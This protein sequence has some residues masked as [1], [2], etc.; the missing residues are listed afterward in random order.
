MVIIRSGVRCLLGWVASF[1]VTAALCFFS[2][3]FVDV[4]VAR[5]CSSLR[6]YY[7]D[8]I[9][10]G[11]MPLV[12]AMAPI[13]LFYVAKRWRGHMPSL[14]EE[15][16]ALAAISSF[17]ALVI[18]D[19]V[20]KPLFGRLPVDAYLLH[21][22]RSGFVLL[23]GDRH[24][25]FPSG[26]AAIIS[27]VLIVLSRFFP[28]YRRLYAAAMVGVSVLLVGGYWHFVSDIVA[29]IFVGAS[30]AFASVALWK[31]QITRSE[32]DLDQSSVDRGKHVQ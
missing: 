5:M 6:R 32:R 10:I 27:S 16:A 19:L 7:R 14:S 26:H 25:N 22:W 28:R 17:V 20:L 8:D 21:D 24:S 15:A 30:A 2:V 23:H 4:P 29:G 12:A 11:A 1:I 9:T 3:L 31:Y 18:C 13:A